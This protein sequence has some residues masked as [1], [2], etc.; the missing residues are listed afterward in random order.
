[1]ADFLAS[2]SDKD[3]HEWIPDL[4]K[5]T[6]SNEMALLYEVAAGYRRSLPEPMR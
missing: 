1:M 2:V 5:R 6:N 4:A 3:H